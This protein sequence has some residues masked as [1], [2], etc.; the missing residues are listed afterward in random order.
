M[1]RNFQNELDKTLSLIDPNVAPKKLLL[2]SCCAPCSSYVLEYLSQYFSITIF[3]FNPNI[4]PEQEYNRRL[5]EQKRLIIE[6]NE[7]LENKVNFIEG[8][9]NPAEFYNTVKGLEY[10]REGSSRCFLCYEL[11]LRH[12]AMLAKADKFDYFTTTLSVSPHKNAER[13]NEIGERLTEEFGI[14]HLP[15]DFKKREGYKRSLELSEKYGL[16][17]QS[18]CGCEF[19]IY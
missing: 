8:E 10:E 4:F 3:Y 9:F 14:K 13:I 2:H 6:L 17:R 1:S 7:T 12:T 15:C 16:Y 18:Y 5:E 19:S 11:R